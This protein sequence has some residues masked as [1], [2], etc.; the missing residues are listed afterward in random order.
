MALISDE[1]LTILGTGVSVRICA[2]LSVPSF[3]GL[4]SEVNDCITFELSKRGMRRI[5]PL[6]SATTIKVALVIFIFVWS[7]PMM[8]DCCTPIF[9]KDIPLDEPDQRLVRVELLVLAVK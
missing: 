8:P 7:K 1:L 4:A 3:A 6:S 2:M 9:S 5:L